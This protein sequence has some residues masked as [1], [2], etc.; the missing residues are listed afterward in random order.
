M[1]EISPVDAVSDVLC[2][3][4]WHTAMALRHTKVPEDK[5]SELIHKALGEAQ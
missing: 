4:V 3:L 1:A 2:V 5:I